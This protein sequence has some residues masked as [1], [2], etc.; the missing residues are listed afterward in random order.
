M[1]QFQE[2]REALMR[3]RLLVKPRKTW[4]GELARSLS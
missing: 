1:W 2:R 4:V 3:Q